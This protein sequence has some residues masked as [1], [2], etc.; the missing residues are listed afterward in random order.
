LGNL[1]G[2]ATT[3]SYAL[4]AGSTN[5]V[6]HDYGIFAATSQSVS[7]SQIDMMS[8]TPA[9]GGLKITTV[10]A[11]GT[12]NLSFTSSNPTDGDIELFVVNRQYGYSQS[13]D[14]SPVYASIGGGAIS[15]TLK[16]PFTLRGDAELYGLYEVYVTASNGVFIE[17]SRTVRFKVT[18]ESD[19]LSVQTAEPL[20]FI[21]Y[22]SNAIMMYSSSLHPADVYNG[23]ASQVIFSGSDDATSL[24]VFPGTLNIM[25]YTWTLTNLKKLVVDSN[26][27]LTYLGG[28]PTGCT[29]ASAADCGLTE[30]PSMASSS[31]QYLNVPN[32]NIVANLSL[33]PSMSYLDVS[34][35]YYV[36]FPTVMPAGMTVLKSDGLGIT[37]TPFSLPDTLIS[38]SFARCPQLTTWL[39][40]VFPSSLKYFDIN[41]SPL[42]NI[43]SAIP[44][45]LLYINVAT[46][47]LG[48]TEIGNIGSGLDANGLNNGYFAFRNNPSSG[49]APFVGTWL[50]SLVGKGWTVVS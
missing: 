13:L 30:L 45:G 22:P 32:N 36:S 16:Y 12:I 50:P 37:Y 2:T 28:I 42:T 5:D 3:A 17:G 7:S 24:L 15:G 26:P 10:E 31:V 48:P 8:V 27:G 29:S 21:T 44:A 6:T 43:P 38:M 40:P 1:T 46:C 9:L 49:S 25:Q 18:S 39:S 20:R 23:S 47:S 33:S 34:N 35:N 41:N 4:T 19:Q 14:A 11:Y